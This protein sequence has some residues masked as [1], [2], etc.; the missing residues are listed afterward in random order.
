LCKELGIFACVRIFA[1]E[2]ERQA[3]TDACLV[4][5]CP[6]ASMVPVSWR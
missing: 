2:Q 3:K 6:L 1:A 4:L 5:L